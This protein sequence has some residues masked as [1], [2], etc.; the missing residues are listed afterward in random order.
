MTSK[1]FYVK[2]GRK[3]KPIKEYD[4]ELVDAYPEGCHVTVCRPGHLIRRYH[5]DP[6]YASLIAASVVAEDAIVDAIIK[7]STYKSLKTELTERQKQLM[8]ELST[9]FDKQDLIFVKPSAIEATRAGTEAMIKEASKLMENPAVKA[10]YE[11][12]ITVAKLCS[13]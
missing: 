9:S 11:H 1:T 3:Y 12:F 10:A 7:N 2:V 8:Q 4:Q 6:D 13:K 5:I